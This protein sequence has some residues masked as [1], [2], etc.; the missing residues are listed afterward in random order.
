MRILILAIF[1]FCMPLSGYAKGLTMVSKKQTIVT[2]FLIKEDTN[3]VILSGQYKYVLPWMEF[4]KIN[5]FNAEHETRQAKYKLPMQHVVATLVP[6]E[7][8]SR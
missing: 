1:L 7:E 6:K 2:G 5:Q 8:M 4:A 3:A